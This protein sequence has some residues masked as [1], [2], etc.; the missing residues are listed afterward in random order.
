MRLECVCSLHRGVFLMSEVPLHHSVVPFGPRGEF[1]DEGG[2]RVCTRVLG[3]GPLL[4]PTQL[5]GWGFTLPEGTPPHT[6]NSSHGWTE[7]FI[8]DFRFPLWQRR[9]HH[10]QRGK[11]QILCL[12]L[13]QP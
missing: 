12:D 13:V 7:S 11:E 10:Y 8:L 5:P 9:I 3:V 1:A 4:Y 2:G 6:F